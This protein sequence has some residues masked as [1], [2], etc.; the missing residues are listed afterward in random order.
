[1]NSIGGGFDDTE[2]L[3]AGG[4][5]AAL[6]FEDERRMPASVGRYQIGVLLGAG[7]MAE[8]YRAFDPMLNRAVALKFL[9]ETNREHLTRFLREA[10]AQAQ[11][12]HDNIC[13]VYEAGVADGH[14]FIAMR[15]IDGETLADAA[16][17]MSVDEKVAVLADV[18]EAV[19]AAHR[20]GLVH[21]DLKPNNIMV[22]AS[23][24]GGWHAWVLDFGL[25][26][27]SSMDTMTTI[28]TIM[29][30][31]PYMAPEQARGERA[32]ID[33]RTDVYSLGA[34]LFDL[35]SGRPPFV[36]DS[37]V[38]VML[39][40]MNEDAPSLRA[41]DP[42][43][44]LDLETIV[45]KCLEKD[46]QRRYDSARALAE[47]LRR[48][49]DGEPIAA[50]RTTFVYRW[51][52][53]ARKQPVIATLLGIAFVAVLASMAWAV[54][55]S[56]RSA[57]RQRAAQR[58]GQE[59]ER[60]E[61]VARYANMLP[62]HDVQRERRRIRNAIGT[63]EREMRT[64]NATS[65]APAHYAIGRGYLALRE[66]D[67]GRRHLE[68]A[69]NGDYRAPEVAYALGRV[70]GAQY[71]EQLEEADR[72]ANADARAARR[73]QVEQQY[74]DAA[75]GWLRRS[76]S[77]A[78]ESPAY[79]EALIAFY[80]KRYD[81]ALA[82][83]RQA[84]ADVPWMYE[85]KTLEGDIW[86]ERGTNQFNSGAVDDAVAS[87]TRAG[88]AYREAEAIASSDETVMLGEAEQAFRL[89]V[90]AIARGGDPT[91]MLQRGLAA[92]E[93]ATATRG[94]LEASYREEALLLQRYADWQQSQGQSPLASL[95]RAIA[96]GRNAVA[97]DPKSGAAFLALGSALFIRARYAAMHGEDA[98]P[99]YDASIANLRRS[100]ALEPRNANILMSLANSLRRKAEALGEKGGN[101][102]ALLNESIVY[103]DR[104]T[105]ANP[106][107]PNSFNDRGLAFM[108]R[109]EWE[110]NN[111]IDP[112]ASYEESAHSLE[113]AIAINPRFSV[114]LLNLG[115]V[116]VDRASA[117]LQAG[118]D[119]RPA[120]QQAN[121]TF[122]AALQ[123]NPKLAFAYS[124]AGIASVI[125]AQW[126]LDVGD[127]PRPWLERGKAAFAH[128]LEIN[129]QHA[130]SYLYTASLLL[131][132][133][134]WTARNGGDP[135]A[136][137]DEAR[138]NVRRS[139]AIRPDSGDTLQVAA[140]IEAEAARY[141]LAQHRSADAALRAAQAS[142]D[143]AR[144][145]NASDAKIFYTAADVAYLRGN[146]ADAMQ[147]VD[148]A[149]AL[150]PRDSDS[151]A[152]RGEL[153]LRGH[154][155][156]GALGEIDR[157]I[158]LKPPAR[159]KWAALREEAR[160]ATFPP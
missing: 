42:S 96:F 108:T 31:P 18:A 46:P 147:F 150:D 92:A 6:P 156:K 98:I 142:I 107:W 40:V 19:H 81:A 127:D 123:L 57:E 8:V 134:Q 61:A 102:L 158:A 63:I 103:Y 111:G 84:F 126:A 85:A 79:G 97:A 148:R 62:L 152:L 16:P 14:A 23:P 116:H 149:L 28:G 133:A 122:A 91:E 78:G 72:I 99:L 66:Y 65:A 136:L 119:P 89:M 29:G 145:Q 35:L 71:Q 154:D 21:R 144:Q 33:R 155:A 130:N 51:M 48:Y 94:D 27:D 54:T 5:G 39:K 26:R 38:A 73:K 105:A 37:S 80:E 64:L 100:V 32:S 56:I 104:A 106:Q 22:E 137:L 77:A 74:R 43:I 50:R 157:A 17:R 59:I 25:A 36:A 93:R 146:D 13:D 76:S 115:T 128:A 124:N 112:T 47:D 159:G 9:R 67:L 69:W 55:T 132:G 82:R 34:T 95:D 12:G 70:I 41:L 114:A 49:L 52:V 109:G 160:R 139:D 7:G 118:R 125:G 131:A 151:H 153:L 83:A 90:V 113:R 110:A 1:M 45:L 60:I 2:R 3:G 143:R 10:R 87:Y 75:L 117:A 44:P 30:T 120:V 53:R 24:E 86:T 135:T 20:T 101:P 138:A 58:F 88:D 141:A 4:D 15:C 68:A 11:V 129:P 121:D 140:S